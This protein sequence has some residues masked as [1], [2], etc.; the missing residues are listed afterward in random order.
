ME[1]IV[2]AALLIL[3]YCFYLSAKDSGGIK[4][5]RDLSKL[6]SIKIKETAPQLKNTARK[7]KFWSKVQR[8]EHRSKKK[9]P[10]GKVTELKIRLH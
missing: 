7:I 6:I 9:F 3:F 8:A 1:P 5:I 2:F 10:Q 4:F